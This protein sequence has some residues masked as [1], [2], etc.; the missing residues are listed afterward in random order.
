MRG[1]EKA[2]VV[3]LMCRVGRLVLVVTTACTVL[4]T[5]AVRAESA[6]AGAQLPQGSLPRDPEDMSPGELQRLFD[7]YTL[8]RA[9]EALRLSDQQYGKFA[10]RLRELQRVRRANVHRRAQLL[11]RL[12]QLSG[13]TP[14]ASEQTLNAALEALHEHDARAQVHLRRAYQGVD[15][16]L[17]ASQRARF[18]VIE[19]QI[20]RRQLELVALARER[21]REQRPGASRDQRPPPRPRLPPE[22]RR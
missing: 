10:V 16:V 12:N 14:P 6:Q 22:P 21:R 9:Q 19:Q 20:E 8:V 18:R 17:D 11:R 4:A 3:S 2:T 7:A 15:E 13:Q 5:V 1:H